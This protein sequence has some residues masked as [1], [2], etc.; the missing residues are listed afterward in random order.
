MPRKP[1]NDKPGFEAGIARLE[2]IVADL[3][4]GDL[5]LEQSLKLYEEGAQLID[6]CRKQLQQAETRIE[7]IRPTADGVACEPFEADEE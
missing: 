2:R 5:E 1:D 3:E 6:A 4:K 7:K